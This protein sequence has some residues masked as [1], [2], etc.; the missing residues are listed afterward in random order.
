MRLDEVEGAPDLPEGPEYGLEN[1]DGRTRA[2]LR[3]LNK[4]LAEVVGNRLIATAA[5]IPFDPEAALEQAK[6]ARKKASRVPEVREVVGV[7]A[8]MAGQWSTA[9]SELKAAQRLTGTLDHVAMIA[10]AERASGNPERAVDL[11]REHG[12]DTKIDVAVR[13]ELL[14]VAA[15]ARRDMGQGRAATTMLKVPALHSPKTDPWVARLRYAYAEALL[16]EGRTEEGLQWL[17]QAA[18]ADE[19][20]ESGAA[21]RILELEGVDFTDT[22]DMDA[23]EDDDPEDDSESP[24]ESGDRDA[25]EGDDT[26][27][28]R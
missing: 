21:E 9:L 27:E 1:L 15:G 18:A 6:Y 8:Y 17:E 5:L 26:P 25:E 2:A 24:A 11:F 13:V 19:F 10:D 23:E 20:G 16:A 22:E 7:A 12:K 28:Q 14:I 3:S 4:Q